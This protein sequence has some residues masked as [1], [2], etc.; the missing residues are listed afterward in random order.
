MPREAGPRRAATDDVVG[1]EGMEIVDRV[2]LGRADPGPVDAERGH[3]TLHR[4]E[5]EAGL[6]SHRLRRRVAPPNGPILIAPR[7]LRG[8]ARPRNATNP[9][10]VK[11]AGE[12][13]SHAQKDVSGR[14]R[15]SRWA[16]MAPKPS[17]IGRGRE[18]RTRSIANPGSVATPP[19]YWKGPRT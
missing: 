8:F 3:P 16:S 13:S 5:H 9:A 7:T 4:S 15:A 18:K 14:P 2:R 1:E 12:R 11:G 19:E 10:S 17:I 6:F